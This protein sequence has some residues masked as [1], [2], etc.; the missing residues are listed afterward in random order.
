LSARVTRSG[1]CPYRP[2]GVGE[3]NGDRGDAGKTCDPYLLKCCWCAYS[4]A[5]TRAPTTT[6][7]FPPVP[8]PP[9]FSQ[10]FTDKYKEESSNEKIVVTT[11]VP[12]CV[13]AVVLCL[14]SALVFVVTADR[15][16]RSSTGVS[17]ASGGGCFKYLKMALMSTDLEERSVQNNA[18]GTASSRIV[19]IIVMITIFTQSLKS[20]TTTTLINVLPV[21]ETACFVSVCKETSSSALCDCAY[22]R[23]PQLYGNGCKADLTAAGRMYADFDPVRCALVG[24]IGDAGV[25]VTTCGNFAGSDPFVFT[26]QQIN[27]NLKMICTLT[28]QVPTFTPVTAIGIAF[29][30]A[31]TAREFPSVLI[32]PVFCTISRT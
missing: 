27:Q 7:A 2:G 3:P 32:K 30:W 22:A 9:P 13:T 10:P 11:L 21:T 31:Q 28:E 5:P 26:A 4:F 8:P 17:K 20:T 23:N 29:G 6:G 25:N 14:G 16:T 1:V 15:E 18:I 24:D 12:L 19:A